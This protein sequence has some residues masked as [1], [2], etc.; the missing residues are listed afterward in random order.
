MTRFVLAHL[1]DPH[2]APPPLPMT[3]G[4]VLS[5][6]LLSR[7]SW[8]RK[9]RFEHRPQVL[10]A[11]VADL[12]AHKPDHVAVTG[13][14]TNFAAPEEFAAARTWLQGL[15][16]PENVTVIP[17]NHDALVQVAPARGL[18]QWADFVS[19]TPSEIAFPAVRI[20]G[21]VALIG[22]CSA[23]P[24]RPGSAAGRVGQDQ[25][26]LLL[27]TLSDLGRQ[28]LFRVRADPSPAGR[29]PG[30]ETQAPAGRRGGPRGDPAKRARSWCCT[31]TATNRR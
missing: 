13:D 31:A 22:L 19:D 3:V 7:L 16:A 9:R 25:R 12:I 20:R 1:S 17:G 27:A 23:I 18:R 26:E 30:Q 4:N 29:R 2:L 21:A 11:I 5:K 8:A 24:T 6:R 15:G 10:D 28:G 14:L